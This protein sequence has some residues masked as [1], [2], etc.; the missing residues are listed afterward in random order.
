MPRNTKNSTEQLKRAADDLD[1]A[2]NDSPVKKKK[3]KSN[4]KEQVVAPKPVPA[5]KDV[6][7]A[8]P[9]FINKFEPESA[10]RL[11]KAQTHIN[12]AVDKINYYADILTVFDTEQDDNAVNLATR[13]NSK[14]EK[15]GARREKLQ[16]SMDILLAVAPKKKDGVLLS[17]DAAEAFMSS[18]KPYYLYFLV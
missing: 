10:L 13:A 14:I 8:D 7:T 2:L 15:W 11:T 4:V 16:K 18:G 17:T 5:V 9:E 12:H 3:S 6:S 1:E